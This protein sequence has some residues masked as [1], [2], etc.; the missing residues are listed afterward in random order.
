MF[1]C[2]SGNLFANQKM[3]FEIIKISELLQKPDGPGPI[4]EYTYW[5]EKEAA[6]SVMVEQLKKPTFMKVSKLLE[7]TKSPIIDA[8]VH[9]QLDLKKSYIQARDNVKFLYTILR[10]LN[11]SI[12]K[13]ACIFYNIYFLSYNSNF[14]LGQKICKKKHRNFISEY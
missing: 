12:C 14:I 2:Q 9:Y 6:L 11:V 4:A 1:F 3:N 13:Y 5:H 8:F 7:K 10:Y